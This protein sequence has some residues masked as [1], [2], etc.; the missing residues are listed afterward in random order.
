MASWRTI[1]LKKSQW[2]VQLKIN[3]EPI[4]DDSKYEK[5]EKY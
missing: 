3:C 2:P 5:Q 4:S 1:W